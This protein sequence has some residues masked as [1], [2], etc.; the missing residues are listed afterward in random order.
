MQEIQAPNSISHIDDE[1]T[2]SIFLAG[3]IELNSA[4]RWQDA[5][6]RELK[7]YDIAVFNPRRDD[8]DNS[9]RQ[10]IIDTRFREQVEWELNAISAASLVVFYFDSATKSPISLLELG[11]C[12]AKGNLIVCCPDGFWRKGNVEVICHKYK[13]PMINN[14][15]NLISRIKLILHNAN[16]P[17]IKV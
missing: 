1:K 17:T 9:I 3:S 16:V 14:L 11:L 2:L 4:E 6:L 12:A 7:G 10:T 13:I 8:W 15:T 5:V